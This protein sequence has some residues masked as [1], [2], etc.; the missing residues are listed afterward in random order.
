M[1]D[2]LVGDQ[3]VVVRVGHH[4]HLVIVAG[5]CRR[6]CQLRGVRAEGDGEGRERRDSERAVVHATLE[7]LPASLV[8]EHVVDL[9]A[10][11]AARRHG[12]AEALGLGVGLIDQRSLR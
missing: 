1:P 12:I 7:D 10:I 11:V 6:G 2:D 9:L 8:A 5:Q 3:G 4:G